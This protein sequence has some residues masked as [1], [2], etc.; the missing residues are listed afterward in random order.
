MSVLNSH[1]SFRQKTTQKQALSAHRHISFTAH[2]TGYM[3]HVMGISHPAFAT[4]KGQVLTTL[5][6]PLEHWSE[7]TI[8]GSIRKTLK[9]RHQMLD[10]ALEDLI[11]QFPDLQVIEIAT[12]LSPRGW[13]FRQKYPD[14]VFIEVDLPD[15][16]QTK[17]QALI[18]AGQS[19]A[20][21]LAIDLFTPQISDMFAN[22][23]TDQPV[24]VI[25][26]GLV[27]YFNQA[28]LKTL[29]SSLAAHGQRFKAFHYLTDLCPEPVQHPFAQLVWK[30]SRLLGAISR[31]AFS[32]HFQTPQQVIHFFKDCGYD[33]VMI[34]Q[35][36]QQQ[37]TA[38]SEQ[39]LGDFVWMVHAQK[40]HA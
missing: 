9:Q 34:E 4:R 33:E 17:K 39:H 13:S 29:W 10:V 25:S 7:K 19:D 18:Q 38:Y 26:E 23:R 2:Y 35:P 6:K 12:G 28:M 31:S 3:W 30:S 14:L 24:V 32:F 11:S 20:T 1:H 27:N 22:L 21:V 15:M 37:K 36:A 16:A 5:L 8:G 40:H